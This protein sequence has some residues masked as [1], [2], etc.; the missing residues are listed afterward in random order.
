MYGV[1]RSYRTYFGAIA[2]NLRAEA[3]RP[4]GRVKAASAGA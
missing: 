4:E 3:L 1:Y 2:E